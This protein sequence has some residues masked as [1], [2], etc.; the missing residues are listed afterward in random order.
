MQDGVNNKFLKNFD[1]FLG[2]KMATIP[3]SGAAITKTPIQGEFSFS[4][5]IWHS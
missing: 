1:F 2:S 5:Q 4:G 3:R